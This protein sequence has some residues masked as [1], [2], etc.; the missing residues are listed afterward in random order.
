MDVMNRSG[1]REISSSAGLL[2]F[3]SVLAFVA[4]LVLAG[5]TA[6]ADPAA[7]APPAANIV[8]G[9]DPSLFTVDHPE[10]FP[11]AAAIER[12]TKS[13]LVVTGTVVPDVARNVPVVSLA[14]GRVVAIHARLGD[15]VKKGDLLLTIRSDDVAGGFDAYRKAVADELLARKQLNRAVDLYAHGAIAEQDLEV[16]QDTEE[17]A[18]VTLATAT[19]HLRL[20]GNDPDKPMGMVDIIAPTS[21]VI[22][23][24]E[25]TNAATVQ[26]YSSPSPFTISDLSSVW[27]VCD[28]YEND[29]PN[30][31]LGDSAD[32]TL[33]AYPGRPFKGKVSN[34]GAVLDPS[35]RT[36]KVRIEVENP[37][38]IRLG[39]FAKAIFRGQTSEMHTIVPASAVLRM[40]D[41][42]FVFVPAPD[43]KFRRVEV[44]GGDVLNDN[45]NLQEIKSGLKPGQQVVT[46]ALVLD[47]VLAQ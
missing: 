39:M 1:L 7:E 46:N 17:D 31:R 27:I 16:A 30:V 8:P 29:L 25:V 14:S 6:H 40:H 44:V 20:L 33:N 34:I 42:D 28:V 36:A 41:R 32:I 13:E 37:G 3:F 21:G 11:L 10:Q 19:E 18:K 22:T 2:R 43:K 45:T 26:A 5:C 38:M 15:T 4:L 23:D 35:I 12:P 47:H 24:Q 9:A